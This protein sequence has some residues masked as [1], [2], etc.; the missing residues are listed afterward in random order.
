MSI[1]DKLKTGAANAGNKAK[2]LVEVNRLKIQNGSKKKDIDQIYKEIGKSTYLSVTSGSEANNNMNIQPLI[3]EIVNLE[4]EIKDNLL[5]IKGL[6]DERDCICG[7]VV[8]MNTK[9]CPDCGHEL[10]QL[11]VEV[12]E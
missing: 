4:M 8:S 1:L 11:E 2:I 9:F 3:E 12:I 6:S 5:H 7:K 10:T